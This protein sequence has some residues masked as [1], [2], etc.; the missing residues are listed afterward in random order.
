M[1][2][3]PS[4]LSAD[5]AK[6]GEEVEAITKGGADWIH[7]DVMD[8]H[9][10]P[11][12][13]IGPCVVG[14]IRSHTNLHF[15]T[16]L[17]IDHPEQYVPQFLKSGS[18]RICFHLEAT[19]DPAAVLAK[20][21]EGGAKTGIALKPGTPVE[22][23]YPYLSKTD[24]VLVMTV[25]PGF[26][27]QKFMADMMDKVKAIK[28]KCPQMLVQIDGGVNLETI[29]AA[30]RAGVDVCVAGTAVFGKTDYA[31]AIHELKEKAREALQK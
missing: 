20:I 11:N 25:E 3:A 16:H 15:D 22:K 5:F 10:V 24:M 12:I 4:I 26:G 19:E 6:L 31:V 13:T 7:I 30:A 27:G 8:G 28:E 2:I 21:H 29:G 23:V 1:L 14:A 9:F 17:M 18:D